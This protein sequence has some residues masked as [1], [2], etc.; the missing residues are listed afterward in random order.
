MRSKV[1]NYLL[2][3]HNSISYKPDEFHNELE[4]SFFS[5]L[6]QTIFHCPHI[7]IPRTFVRHK[8]EYFYKSCDNEIHLSMPSNSIYY[9]HCI[10]IDVIHLILYHNIINKVVSHQMY[11]SI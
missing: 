4:Y 9:I 6:Q 5:K 8:L 7:L 1:P 3:V 11:R 10:V 2:Y